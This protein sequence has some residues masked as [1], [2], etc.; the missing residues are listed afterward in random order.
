MVISKDSEINDEWYRK[1]FYTYFINISIQYYTNHSSPKRRG[2]NIEIQRA[3]LHKEIAE[4]Q[5]IL[6][7]KFK[8]FEKGVYDVEGDERWNQLYTTSQ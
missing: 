6:Q 1:G 4:S 2:V 8:K 3:N 7:E 5:K